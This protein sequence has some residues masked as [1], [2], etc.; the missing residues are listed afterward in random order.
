MTRDKLVIL[1][2]FGIAAAIGLLGVGY[3]HWLSHRAIRWWGDKDVSLVVDAPDVDGCCW[4]RLP[5]IPCPRFPDCAKRMRS[6]G[7]RI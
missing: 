7:R 1:S 6:G 3:H 2:M 4:N 5:P